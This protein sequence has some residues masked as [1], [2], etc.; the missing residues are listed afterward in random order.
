MVFRPN[1]VNV[2]E[3]GKLLLSAFDNRNKRNGF[4][5]TSLSRQVHPDSCTLNNYVYFFNCRFPLVFAG[6]HENPG[7]FAPVKA[8]SSNTYVVRRMSSTEA[9][10]LFHTN[11]FRSFHPITNI[12]PQRSVKWL[13]SELISWIL[14]DGQPCQGILH[15]PEN[16]DPSKKYP[17]IFNYYE[18]RTEGLNIFHTPELAGHNI[19]IP[20]YVSR[21]Y[22]VFEPDMYYKTGKTAQSILDVAESAAKYLATLSFVDSHRMG[23]Q[24]QSFGGYETNVIATGSKLFA[25][26]CEMAGPTNIISEYGSIRPLGANNQSA[27]DIGQRNLGAFPWEHPKVF[28]ENSPV[29]HISNIT[30]PLLIVHNQGDRAILYSQAIELFMGMRRAGK[31]VWMLEYDKESHVIGNENN[32][33]DFTIR[34]Q[35]FFDHYLKGLP[36]P[37]WMTQGILATNKGIES[38][39]ELE[40]A[41]NCGTAEHKC[42]VCNKWNDQ[43]KKNPAMFSRPISQWHLETTAPVG[44]K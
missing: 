32:Q 37:K 34:M 43:F 19:N 24:G 18:Q 38:G 41:E 3:E 20:W 22:L 40:P 8:R 23:V 12:H 25:A 17:V 28:I 11:D 16:F 4:Y 33:L 39:F 13:N 10:N 15:K 5:K 31:K 2:A 36:P 29:F 14:P 21:D 27:A 44:S 1:V 42:K 26:A 6:A 35:Q 30:T 7:A 9:P